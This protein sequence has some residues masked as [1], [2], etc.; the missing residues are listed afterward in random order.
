MNHTKT[1]L[2]WLVVALAL[3]T[4]CRQGAADYDPRLVVADSVLRQDP[5]SALA[6]LRALDARILP[7]DGDRAYYALLLTQ[8]QYRC[9]VTANSDSLINSA[10]DYYE[11]HTGE[12]EK[13]TRAYIYK[14]AVMEELGQPEEAMTYYKHALAHASP[15][16]AFNQGYARLRLGNIYRDH[17]VADSSD[18][19]LFKEALDYF[20]MVP[21]S[22]YV[23]SCL[24]SIGGC[25]IKSQNN[26]SAMAYLQQAQELAESLHEIE[27]KHIAQTYI[28]DIKMFSHD[29]R[30]INEAK[31]IAMSLLN[32]DE[33]AQEK[34]N[35]LLMVAA[36]TLA[37]QCKADS[38]SLFLNQVDH[39][40]GLS[41]NLK[42]FYDKCC[43][44]LAISRGNIKDFR[45]HFEHANDL[46]D[47]LVTNAMQQRLRDVE[48]KYDNEAL[49][50]KALKYRTN[51]IMSLLGT[52]LVVSVL[53]I[54][55]MLLMR[56]LS[57]RKRQL[58]ESEDTI[59]RLRN[60]TAQ[61]TS[62]LNANQ[63]MSSELKDTI[64]NQIDVFAQLVEQHSIRSTHSLKKFGDIF[65]KAYQVNQPDGSF[66]TGIRAYANSQ[67]NDI[68][69][70]AS[71][72]FPSLID[73]DFN[74]LS[75]Y[76][77]ELPTTVI[78]ACMGYK[79]IH[80]VYNKKR[81]LAAA[82]SCPNGLDDYIEQF[83]GSRLA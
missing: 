78:M 2:L 38:A 51:W 58:Q 26:D 28:A 47:S 8:A 76:C 48:T 63:A 82:M 46:A 9:Y 20:K 42:V 29:A 41:P 81:R 27:Q 79:E 24:S 36:F 21:D 4:G 30:D 80:S 32:S 70:H 1:F 19:T 52:A 73:S 5:D 49:K 13:L 6:M 10:L 15:S 67:C 25:Y 72:H 12:Q 31:Q 33:A 55:T 35:H 43:A 34:C 71:E 59:E 54:A 56:K 22:F 18:I 77:C 37:K 61:L 45:L 50:Y 66:W 39:P 44:E 23:L 64:R 40:E 68:V 11:R 53:V 3:L 7:G 57:Q 62:L 74:F 75:L 65:E 16:D 69:T 60:D 17:L 14:G 83:K